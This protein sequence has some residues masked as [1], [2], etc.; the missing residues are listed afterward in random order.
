MISKFTFT[1]HS[2]LSGQHA[3][4][5][6]SQSS[7]LRYDDTKIAQRVL[8][9]YRAP[10]GTEIHEYAAFKIDSRHKVLNVKNVREGIEEYIAMKYKFTSPNLAVSSYG[11]KL[12]EHV[13]QL[14]K[15]VFE[16]VRLYIKDGVDCKMTT[17]QPLVYSDKIFGTADTISFRNNVL[18]I[19]DLKTGALKADMEQLATYAALFCLE[20]GPKYGFKPGDIEYELA[21]YQWD[22]I[23]VDN[24][25]VED[26]LP[27]INRIIQ[28]DKVA[29]KYDK[30]E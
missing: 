3:L 12:I 7:W 21:L 15:E 17:E 1:D 13:C 14:P 10:L 2:D 27:I 28:I 23:T 6:P 5:S 8:S 22:E 19:H 11:T 24:P 29:N 9:Q 25:T 26:I 16:V 4:F 18:R 30:E 20:Y